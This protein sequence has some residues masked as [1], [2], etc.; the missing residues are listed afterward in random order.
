MDRNK[1]IVKYIK[2]ETV[3]T[4]SELAKQL[5][6]SWNT[7]EKYLMELALDGVVRRF[8]KS[9]VNIWLLK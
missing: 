6:V 7:A 9:G 2:Q 4:S 5:S 3:V 8:K 1:E